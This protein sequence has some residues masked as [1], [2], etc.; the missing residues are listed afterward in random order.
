MDKHRMWLL[1]QPKCKAVRSGKL[2]PC[3]WLG[4]PM[5]IEDIRLRLLAWRDPVKF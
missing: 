2:T 5:V 4:D 3:G 1:S